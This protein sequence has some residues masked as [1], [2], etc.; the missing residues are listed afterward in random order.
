MLSRMDNPKTL[1]TLST[2]A[3][4][5]RQPKQKQHTT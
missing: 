5:R 4:G 1:E 2:Q 3:T